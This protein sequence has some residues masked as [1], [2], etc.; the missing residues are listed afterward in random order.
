[1]V[2]LLSPTK[3]LFLFIDLIQL[4]EFFIAPSILKINFYSKQSLTQTHL[5]SPPEIYCSLFS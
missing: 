1:M 2:P 4:I 3:I 5:S